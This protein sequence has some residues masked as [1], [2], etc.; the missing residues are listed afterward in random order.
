MLQKRNVSTVLR[1][2]GGWLA[3]ALLATA[4]VLIYANLV[5]AQQTSTEATLSAPALTA[6]ADNGTVELSWA[7]VSGAVRYELWTYWKAAQGWQLVSDSLTGTSYTHSGLTEGVTYY[8]GL[9]ARDAAGVAGPF[10]AYISA[11]VA[12]VQTPTPTPTQTPTPTPSAP[13][14]SRLSAPALTA[15]PAAGAVELSWA[16]VSGAVRYELWTYWKAAQGWQ[17]VSDSLTGTSYTHSGLTEGVTYYYGLRARDAA[18]VAGPFSAYISA[19]VAAVQTPTPTP[20]QT[21]TATVMDTTNWVFAGNVPDAERTALREEVEAVRTWMYD[22]YGV[23][24]RDLTVWVATDAEALADAVDWDI[25]GMDVPPGY[26]GPLSLTPDPFVAIAD[27]GSPVIVL[28][29][30]SNPFYTLLES[31]ANAY[32]HVLQHQLVAPRSLS[33]VE[34]YWLVEGMAMNFDLAYTQSRSGRRPFLGDNG[35]YSPYL[36]LEDAINLNGVMTPGWLRN[37]LTESNFRDGHLVHPIYANSI[38]FAGAHF[39][40]GEAGED[41]VVEFWRLLQQRPTW[42]QAFEEAFGMSIEDFYDS[43]EEWLPDQLPSQVQ[44]SVWLH[45]QGKEALPPEVLNRIRWATA[46]DIENFITSP[47]G[48]VSWGGSNEEG[49]HTIVYGAG[50]RWTGTLSLTFE[51]DQCT[52]QLLGWYK[53]GELTDQAK[54]ATV[55]QFSGESSDLD[56]TI[57]A[58]PDTLPILQETRLSHCN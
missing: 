30:A 42:Q 45:W 24:A 8:Y 15:E 6:E 1:G 32:F 11:T 48:N 19:T 25:G 49:A 28:I 2:P 23:E 13:V 36:D 50:E 5:W 20:T 31:I 12:A 10:S 26:N 46:V 3:V 35:R 53:D 51:T 17:L 21:P 43:F 55:V 57:P 14:A 22:Q 16:T 52:R 58:R 18:G 4:A 44:L 47:P 33:E 7:T 56:W 39:L 54:E 38:A 9:R 27:D 40:V 29:Y 41:S 37:K 34:P